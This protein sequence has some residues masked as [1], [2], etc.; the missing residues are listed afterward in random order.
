M[1]KLNVA[2]IGQGR[3]GKNIHGKYFRSEANTYY[4]VKYVVDEDAF[5]REVAEQIYP[6]CTT[7][8]D[9]TQL[10]ELDDIEEPFIKIVFT[11]DS[12]VY[13]DKIFDDVRYN[14]AK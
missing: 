7:F 9:Y 13:L 4:N 11:T 14:I 1:N 12:K 2:L 5:R 8:S 10:F 6:G 3:S